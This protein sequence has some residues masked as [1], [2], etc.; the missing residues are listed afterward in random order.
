MIID[1]LFVDKKSTGSH[2]YSVNLVL[3]FNVIYD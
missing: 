2:N 3:D 1:G